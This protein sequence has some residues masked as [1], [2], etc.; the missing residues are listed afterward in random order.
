[1]LQTKQHLLTN[2]I[3]LENGV[4]KTFVQ[5]DDFLLVESC[6]ESKLEIKANRKYNL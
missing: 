4:H 6:A 2:Y 5:V 3:F 1:M